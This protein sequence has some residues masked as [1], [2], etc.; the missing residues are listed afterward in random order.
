MSTYKFLLSWTLALG[1][2]TPFAASAQQPAPPPAPAEA[3]WRKFSETPLVVPV[4]GSVVVPAGTW[5]TIRVN[6]VISTDRNVVGDGFAA[7]LAQPLIADG[8]VV[9][10]RGQTLAGRVVEVVK[11]GRIKGRARL[12]LELTELSLVDGR[13]VAVRTQLISYS[14]GTSYGRDATAIA[15][16]TATGAAIGGMAD[17]GFGAGVGA[18]AGA[19][20][21]TIG[22]LATRGRTAEVY[23]EAAITFRLLEPLTVGTERAAAAFRPVGQQDYEAQMAP[24]PA[25]RV[26][27]PAPWY[28]GL[29]YG[30]GYP[31]YYSPLWYG[32]GY[33]YYG[34][35]R[36]YGGGY[37]RGGYVGHYGGGHRGRGR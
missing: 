5:I 10:R 17:G 20:A 23:P 7:T 1:V 13:Q 16:T 32:R 4:P 18:L 35:P 31:Y 12:G 6:D 33:S 15:A 28:L 36:F 19:A 26:A 2:A 8:I 34:G 25:V 22:V 37:Y 14:P 9:A 30:Y 21:S 3:G 27:Q 11:G 24:R 29:G